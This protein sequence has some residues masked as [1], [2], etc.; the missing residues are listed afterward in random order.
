M[1][2]RLSGIILYTI[3]FGCFSATLLAQQAKP[4]EQ[5]KQYYFV[6]LTKGPKRDQDS[7][8]V[9]KIQKAH[10]EN[11][12]RLAADGKIDIAGPFAD[13][14][15]WRGIF[16]F[17]VATEEE[18]RILLETDMAISSGRL[19]YIIHPWLSMKGASLK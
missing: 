7:A 14:T 19:S 8:T 6:L 9:M 12:E 3:F 1:N 11:I 18:V 10:L 5:F 13:N 2:L 16:I 17:N 4:E 15:D